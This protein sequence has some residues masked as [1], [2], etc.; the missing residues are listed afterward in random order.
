M[1]A[2][3]PNIVLRTVVENEGERLRLP[4]DRPDEGQAECGTSETRFPLQLRSHER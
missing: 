2:E 4:T 1:A 3:Q